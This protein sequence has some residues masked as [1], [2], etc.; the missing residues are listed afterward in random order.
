MK[1]IIVSLLIM[2]MSVSMLVG[3]GDSGKDTNKEPNKEN[4]SNVN[5]DADT[6]Q[7]TQNGQDKDTEKE[8]ETKDEATS[9]NSSNN[10]GMIATDWTVPK[11]EIDGVIYTF[12]MEAQELV[13]NGWTLIN[14]LPIG[15]RPG[16]N[17]GIN[18]TKGDLTLF[19][20]ISSTT[21]AEQKM[22]EGEVCSISYSKEYE[23]IQVPMSFPGGIAL[24]MSR[25][26]VV[27][28]LPGEFQY[29]EK[30]KYYQYKNE[31]EKGK[32][33]VLI[34]LSDDETVVREI[35]YTCWTK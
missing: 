16:A 24:G 22:E 7:N 20:N 28:I 9:E 35:D 34:Y 23:N 4:D 19:T 21:G 11:I 17:A 2:A 31:T 14:K 26:E 15:A 8:S 13:D 12:P 6:N 29:V 30:Y 27:K 3:C 5:Q 33:E 25:E 32:I 10:K 1:K 18:F